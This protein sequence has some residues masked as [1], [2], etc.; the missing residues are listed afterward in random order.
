MSREV[1][2]R[3]D[4][5]PLLKINSLSKARLEMLLHA[6]KGIASEV[7]TSKTRLYFQG[8]YPSY[9]SLFELTH[10]KY[11]LTPKLYR[12]VNVAWKQFLK[13]YQIKKKYAGQGWLCF[14]QDALAE[15]GPIVICEGENDCLSVVGKARK[16]NVIGTIGNFNSPAILDYLRKHSQGRTFYLAFDKDA[17]GAKYT[18]RYAQAINDGRG[19]ARV[20][21]IPDE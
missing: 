11:E 2:Y 21:E 15:E 7:L 10:V 14:N 3:C 18:A 4:I 12:D 8:Q 19:Q 16:P 5:E 20:I 6:I 9:I 17:A 13:Y 1:C